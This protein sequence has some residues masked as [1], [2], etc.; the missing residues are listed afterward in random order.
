MSD[1]YR[2]T[3]LFAHGWGFDRHFFDSLIACLPQFNCVPIDLGFKGMPIMPKFKSDSSVLAIGHSLGFLWLLKQRPLNWHGIVSING[4]PRFT[5]AEDYMLAQ[6]SRIL[7]RMQRQFK[8]DAGR[9][10]TDFMSRCGYDVSGAHYDV[11]RMGEGLSWL[12][13]WDERIALANEK[14]PV[15]AL[16]GKT[17][18]IISPAMTEMGFKGMASIEWHD[19]GHLLPLEA[20]SWC[21]ERLVAAWDSIS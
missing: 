17:D 20:P 7:D 4:F 10:T 18:E 8:K 6:P 16:A 15:F 21:A 12:E 11:G 19:G 3:F 9:V 1:L 5:E 13:S 2:P 14:T